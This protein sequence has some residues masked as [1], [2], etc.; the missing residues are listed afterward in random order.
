MIPCCGY[1][2]FGL[3]SKN[4]DHFIVLDQLPCNRVSGERRRD[5][6][7]K[8]SL[9]NN[10][11]TAPTLELKSSRIS[12]RQLQSTANTRLSSS[13]NWATRWPATGSRQDA[14]TERT[15]SSLSPSLC[16]G[17]TIFQANK[18]RGG[19]AHTLTRLHPQRPSGSPCWM[20]R[21]I[22]SGRSPER[23]HF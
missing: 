13:G 21:N 22:P 16:N 11:M 9:P 23:D 14:A 4:R 3:V 10:S 17:L 19:R 6:I 5:N 2:R 1:A 7:E 8:L 18:T 20:A 15:S 12:R